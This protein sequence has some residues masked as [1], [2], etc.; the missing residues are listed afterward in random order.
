MFRK[1]IAQAGFSQFIIIGVLAVGIVAS[2]LLVQNGVNFVPRAAEQEPLHP[3]AG[4]TKNCANE[5][6]KE[7]C[8]TENDRICAADTVTYCDNREGTPRAMRK[9]GGYYD[10]THANTDPASGCVFDYREVSGKNT[11]CGKT[12]SKSGDVVYTTTEEAKKLDSERAEE[13]KKNSSSSS[14]SKS[15]SQTTA[16]TQAATTTYNDSKVANN[17]VRFYAIVNGAGNLC[18]PADLGV[19]VKDEITVNGVEGRLM[20]CSDSDSSLH[21]MIVGPSGLIAVPEAQ[22]SPPNRDTLEAGFKNLQD[23]RCKAGL[24][25]DPTLC[26]KV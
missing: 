9:S 6:N 7:A 5:A 12:E 20:M 26:K 2:T 18:V 25:T 13:S 1:E 14:G 10:P 17:L 21:W 15:P 22:K 3:S 8:Q 11:E 16:C 19:P 23:A 24:D 4:A